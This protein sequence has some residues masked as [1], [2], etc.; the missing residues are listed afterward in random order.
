M[1]LLC[2]VSENVTRTVYSLLYKVTLCHLWINNQKLLT[3][4][5]IIARRHESQAPSSWRRRLRSSNTLFVSLQALKLG[6]MTGRLLLT[7][8]RCE[9]H[10][11]TSSLRFV[12]N[13]TRVTVLGVWLRHSGVIVCL[14]PVVTSALCNYFTRF[15]I[16][17]YYLSLTR[18]SARHT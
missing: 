6:W 14:R 2:C 7:V 8:H 17:F 11:L 12:W 13:Y 15:F 3:C 4:D 18:N 1:W 5:W 16:Y 10:V 9:T